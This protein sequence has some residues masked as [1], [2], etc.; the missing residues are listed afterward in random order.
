M[1]Q[2]TQPPPLKAVV[3]FVVLVVAIVAALTFKRKPES[4]AEN[5]VAPQRITVKKPPMTEGPGTHLLGKINRAPSVDVVSEQRG[6]VDLVAPPPALAKSFPQEPLSDVSAGTS[7]AWRDETD[8]SAG[9]GQRKHRVMDGD[10]LASLADRYLGDPAR[11][12]EFLKAN[13]AL[14]SNPELLPIGV[15]LVIPARSESPSDDD[16]ELAP[17]APSNSTGR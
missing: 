9:A 14:I 4:S 11:A 15:E 12:G 2:E 5:G 1:D 3:I 8:S 6:P 16:E 13:R 17:V 7:S 10:T